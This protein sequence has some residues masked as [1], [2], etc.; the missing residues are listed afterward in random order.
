MNRREW[1]FS[2][3]AAIPFLRIGASRMQTPNA[4]QSADERL[5]VIETRLGGRLGV[6]A[7][8]TRDAKRLEHRSSERF[9][10]CST[11]KLLLVA[12]ILTLVDAKQE[13][14]DRVILYSEA[15]L[16]EYAPITKAHVKEGGMAVS[17]LCAAAIEYSDNTAANLLLK[18]LGGPSQVTS[19]ARTLGD[20]ITRLDRKEP[21]L[22]SAIDGDPRDT[23]NPSSML[24]DMKELLVDQNRLSTRSQKQLQDWLIGNAT[25]AK[26]L[27]AGLPADWRIGDKTGSGKNGATND[28]AICWPP[29]RS[30][31]LVTAYFVGSTASYEDRWAALAEVGRIVAAEFA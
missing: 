23:T 8:D 12:A 13:K 28:I 21:D 30:P 22:N 16:L 31:V 25:G 24:A 4:A 26:Q 17:D 6:S 14:L 5:R 27:R 19:Y 1:L 18:V 7:F 9:P 3:A 11:F 2:A 20:T 29:N 10:M 15:D